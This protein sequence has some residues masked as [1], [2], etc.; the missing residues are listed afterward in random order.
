MGLFLRNILVTPR[1]NARCAPFAEQVAP[2]SGCSTKLYLWEPKVMKGIPIVFRLWRILSKLSAWRLFSLFC[3]PLFVT[4]QRDIQGAFNC[5]ITWLYLT[6]VCRSSSQ[7]HGKLK[8][9]IF[10]IKCI[11]L[12]IFINTEVIP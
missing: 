8:L 6:V 11:T 10:L 1:R 9:G 7:C 2:S 5:S 4:E 12:W 3:V